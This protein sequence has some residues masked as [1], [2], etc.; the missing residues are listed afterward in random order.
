MRPTKP[1][2]IPRSLFDTYMTLLYEYESLQTCEPFTTQTDKRI[3]LVV[4]RWMNEKTRLREEIQRVLESHFGEYPVDVNGEWYHFYL[5][6]KDLGCDPKQL[7]NIQTNDWCRLYNYLLYNQ[8]VIP[9]RWFTGNWNGIGG[10]T[11][12]DKVMRELLDPVKWFFGPQSRPRFVLDSEERALLM[13]YNRNSIEEQRLV[14]KYGCP[15]SPPKKD[16]IDLFDIVHRVL[17]YKA[18]GVSLRLEGYREAEPIR[19]E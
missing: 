10:E 8:S 14:Q 13:T 5:T 11:R 7:K 6:Q 3:V 16:H 18:D 2:W 9:V 19:L 15:D 12:S 1:L 4:N 17:N